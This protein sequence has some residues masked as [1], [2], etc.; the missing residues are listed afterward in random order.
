MH[1]PTLFAAVLLPLA[2]VADDL[3][4]TTSTSTLTLTK[5]LTLQRAQMTVVANSTSIT[6]TFTPPTPTSSSEP[7]ATTSADPNGG[8][9]LRAGQMA[10][11]GVAGAVVAILL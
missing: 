3:T 7:A 10:A 1:L 11:L 9:A 6:T 4:T 2:A 5:T 8:L